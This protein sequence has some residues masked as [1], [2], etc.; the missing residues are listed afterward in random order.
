VLVL[1]LFMGISTGVADLS[2]NFI[3]DSVG[4]LRPFQSV[5]GTHFFSPDREWVVIEEP[6]HSPGVIG[7]S[8]PS[9]HAATSMA[10]AVILSLLFRR[11]NPW[12]YLLPVMVGWSR[13]YAGKH[14]P[15]DV[16][17]GWG[18]GLLSVLAVWWVCYVI[19]SHF[20]HRRKALFLG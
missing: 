17:A 11:V 19:F 16:V 1:A 5:E 7:G 6:T 14:F 18:V 4:R 20:P 8:F 2:S 13:I 12:I 3:K 9:S 10:V 15:L